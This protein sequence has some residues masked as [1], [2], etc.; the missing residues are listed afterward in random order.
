MPNNF[1]VS[2]NMNSLFSYELIYFYLDIRC[3]NI[4]YILFV[5]ELLLFKNDSEIIYSLCE[6][7]CSKEI[8]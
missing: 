1:K 8:H 7:T 2:F 4:Y 6:L 3:R 5:E